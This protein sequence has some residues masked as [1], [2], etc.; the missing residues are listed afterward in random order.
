MAISKH[1]LFYHLV[2]FIQRVISRE[3]RLAI[4]DDVVI[5]VIWMQLPYA[6]EQLA[7]MISP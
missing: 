5:H 3:G 1:T 7:L 2:P 6:D 4:T